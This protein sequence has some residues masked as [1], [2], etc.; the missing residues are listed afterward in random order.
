MRSRMLILCAVALS[1]AGALATS[2][3]AVQWR[4]AGSD[5]GGTLKV[6][7]AVQVEKQI[8][9]LSTLAPNV[10]LELSCEIVNLNNLKLEKEGLI[11]EGGK[12]K[13]KGCKAL[14]GGKTTTCE[15]HTAGQVAG[16]IVTE[17]LKGQL[18]L[19]GAKA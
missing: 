15:P 17:E 5:V 3:E 4:I 2:A 9:L 6:P 12:V 1:I 16:T 19:N 13:F 7:I 8:T 14:N 18:S 10:K 11:T